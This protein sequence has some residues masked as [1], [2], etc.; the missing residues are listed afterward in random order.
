M[1]RWRCHLETPETQPG[2]GIW[3]PGAIGEQVAA[4]GVTR[5]RASSSVPGSSKQSPA[6]GR[7]WDR[8]AGTASTLGQAQHLCPPGPEPATVSSDPRTR[9][10]LSRPPW[11]PA[12]AL[13][14]P[15]PQE[16]RPFPRK[17]PLGW[18]WLPGLELGVPIPHLSAQPGAP[19]C[20]SSIH[21]RPVAGSAHPQG[22]GYSWDP[23]EAQPGGH[24]AG[25]QIHVRPSRTPPPDQ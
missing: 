10:E 11:T 1:R 5:G 12:R 4:H 24:N 14:A 20:G 19:T 18:L 13:P 7:E 16:T 25:P 6:G 15:F 8:P 17:C 22:W 2:Q 9:D 23:Q 21:H 3:Y